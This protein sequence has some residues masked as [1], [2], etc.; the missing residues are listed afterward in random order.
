MATQKRFSLR[1]FTSFGELFGNLF[2]KPNTVKFPAEHV[3]IPENYRGSPYLSQPNDCIACGRCVRE[4]PTHCISMEQIFDTSGDYAEP[5]GDFTISFRINQCMM[6]GV[7]TEVCSKSAIKMSS[8]NWML[9]EIVKGSQTLMYQVS[10]PKKKKK[11][12]INNI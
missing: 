12:V 8:E 6:C 4:C 7:C 9:A 2:R 3:P 11:K 5:T 1:V 10:R